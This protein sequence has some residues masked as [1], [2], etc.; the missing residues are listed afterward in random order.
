M[1]LRASAGPSLLPTMLGIKPFINYILH[2]A[3]FIFFESLVYIEL[4]VP[5]H[6]FS[7]FTPLFR[8]QGARTR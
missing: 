3:T 6:L 7:I 1:H 4:P 8:F 5:M 2:E